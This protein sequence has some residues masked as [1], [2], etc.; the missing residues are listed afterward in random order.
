MIQQ[1]L[2]T[3]YRSMEREQQFLNYA[4]HELRT[5]IAV[6]RNNIELLNRLDNERP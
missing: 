2:V 5:P 6:I 1:G 4:S 3:T